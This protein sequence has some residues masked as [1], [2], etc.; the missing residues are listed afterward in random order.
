MSDIILKSFNDLVE[1]LNDTSGTNAKIELLKMHPELRPLI[2]RIW[3]PDTK[4]GV[5]RKGVE[6]FSIKKSDEIET[7]GEIPDSLYELLDNLTTRKWTGDKAKASVIKYYK[8]FPEF[9]DLI[10]RII[11]KK[12]RIRMSATLLLKAFPGIFRIFKVAL[13]EEYDDAIFRKELRESNGVAFMS[14]KI[15]GVRLIT[16]IKNDTVKFYSRTGHEW[17]SLD[18]LRRDF[19]DHIVPWLNDD[20]IENGTV[21]DGELVALDEDGNENFKE[22]VSQSRKKDIQ[23][24]NPRYHIF[25]MISLAV[26]NGEEESPILAQRLETLQSVFKERESK[27][28]DILEQRVYS[29]EEFSKFAKEAR[30]KGWEGVMIRFN[31]PYEGKRTKRLLKYKFFQTEEFTV[32]RVNIEMMPFPNAAGGEDMIKALKNVVILYKDCEVSVGSGFD[33]EERIMFAKDMSKIVGKVISVQ[34][35]EPFQDKKTGKWSLRCPTYRALL[36]EERDF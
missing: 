26:F 6:E 34:F 3:D 25:D 18:T 27:Q 14:K 33:A 30:E 32:Q 2:K 10:L 5:T 17:T 11:E 9:E 24:Q 29:E 12:P 15:D 31:Q 22:T 19:I 8:K 21:F 35:Q 23:M 16:I 7:K 1:K 28:C 20:E 13:S 36:G 4:T